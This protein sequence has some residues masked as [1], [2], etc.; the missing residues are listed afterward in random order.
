MGLG[1]CVKKKLLIPHRKN[2]CLNPNTF[3]LD[4][5]FGLKNTMSRKEPKAAWPVFGGCILRSVKYKCP[6]FLIKDSLGFEHLHIGAMAEFSLS[7]PTNDLAFQNEISPNLN[8][9]LI[10]KQFDCD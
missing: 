10:S 1:S 4:C 8:L 6:P 5:C 7:I 9:F 3:P 2:E